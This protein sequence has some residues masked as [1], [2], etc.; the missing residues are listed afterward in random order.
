MSKLRFHHAALQVSCWAVGL[1]NLGGS[2]QSKVTGWGGKTQVQ[3]YCDLALSVIV[4][5]RGDRIK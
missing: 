4:V 3:H 1:A 5:A 2:F